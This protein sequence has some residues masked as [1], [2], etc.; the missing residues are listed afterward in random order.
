[1]T[2]NQQKIDEFLRDIVAVYEKHGLVLGHEDW[3][4]AFTVE[5]MNPQNIEWLLHA[6]DGID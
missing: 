6:L 3:Q 4:G 1:M 5:S 2:D